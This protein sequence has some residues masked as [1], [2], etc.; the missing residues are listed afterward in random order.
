[1][2]AIAGTAELGS[3]ALDDDQAFE[4]LLG[5][6]IE[7]GYRFA[8]ALLHDP[9]A[10]EDAVQEASLKAWRKL[11][12]LRSPEAVR[13][14]FLGIVANQCRTTSRTRWWQVAKIAVTP[15]QTESRVAPV[16]DSI[17]LRRAIRRLRYPERT[18]LVMYF[19]LDLSA[20]EVAAAT[21]STPGAVRR[22]LYRTLARLRPFLAEES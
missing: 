3:Q 11:S 19:Y 8:C 7:P 18:A 22:R 6:L 2:D 13:P 21:H 9:Q 17:D 16:A 4:R 20:E 15:E 12:Q 1:M 5:P 14:W 10:A